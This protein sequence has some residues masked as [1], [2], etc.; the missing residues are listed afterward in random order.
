MSFQFTLLMGLGHPPLGLLIISPEKFQIFNLFPFGSK[1]SNRI[2]SINNRIKDASAPYLLRVKS[3]LR[4]GQ[5]R[6]VIHT[7]ASKFRKK[8][9]INSVY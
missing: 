1:K 6:S 2:G 9:K 8:V 4:S 7:L 5:G 3:M